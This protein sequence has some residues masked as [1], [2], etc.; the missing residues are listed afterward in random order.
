MRKLHCPLLIL[1]NHAESQMFDVA[2]M[3]FNAIHEN[4][5]LAKFSRF[6]CESIL[7]QIYVFMV[8]FTFF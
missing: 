4:K 5:V 6:T 1:V 7:I 2:N 8:F 3:S